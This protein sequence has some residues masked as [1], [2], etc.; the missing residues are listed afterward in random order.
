M[1]AVIPVLFGVFGTVLKNFERRLE[2][3]EIGERFHGFD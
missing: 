1:I 2:E 3:L